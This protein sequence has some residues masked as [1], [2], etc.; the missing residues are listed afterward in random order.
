[1]KKKENMKTIALV[2]FSFVM[3]GII[4]FAL[5]KWTPLV[6]QILGTTGETVVTKNGTQK[7]EK[8]S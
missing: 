1:M 2:V 6:S 3:G 7:Y 8:N 4:M 5:L